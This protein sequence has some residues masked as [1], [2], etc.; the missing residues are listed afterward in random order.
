M[1][2]FSIY[3]NPGKG[4]FKLDLEQDGLKEA[5]IKVFDITGKMLLTLQYKDIQ[6]RLE[7]EIDLSEYTDGI[8]QVQIVAGNT[9]LH[10]ILIK[11]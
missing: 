1:S 5:N 3:P 8:Y 7:T 10:R 9:L 6:G 11:E 4:I 2:V